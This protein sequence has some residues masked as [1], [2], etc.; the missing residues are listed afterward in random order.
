MGGKWDGGK[1]DRQR[2]MNHELYEAGYNY[3]HA[4]TPGEQRKWLDEWKRLRKESH[5]SD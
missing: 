5:A 4:K 3:A 2:K 1:G